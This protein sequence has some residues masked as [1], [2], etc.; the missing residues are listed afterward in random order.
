MTPGEGYLGSQPSGNG[1]ASIP[2]R[3]S[4]LLIDRNVIGFIVVGVDGAS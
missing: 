1:A 3:A 4:L 2:T